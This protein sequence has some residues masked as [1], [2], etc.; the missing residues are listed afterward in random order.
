MPHSPLL[1]LRFE[2]LGGNGTPAQ[3]RA[4]PWAPTRALARGT[5]RRRLRPCCAADLRAARQAGGRARAW[6]SSH[7]PLWKGA[8]HGPA[9]TRRSVPEQCR[10]PASSSSTHRLSP[11][12]AP[13][14][15]YHLVLPMKVRITSRSLLLHEQ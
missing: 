15:A 5:S 11:G 7:A 10:P 12:A 2:G 8:C 9:A 3:Q 6:N 1:T 4:A 13:C 14:A